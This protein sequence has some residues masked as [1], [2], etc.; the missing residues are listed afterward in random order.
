MT[1]VMRNIA[2]CAQPSIG[3]LC[4]PKATSSGVMSGTALSARAPGSSL[5]IVFPSLTVSVTLISAMAL[6]ST[7]VGSFERIAKSA[8]LPGSRLPLVVSSK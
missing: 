6:G 7:A 2:S 3:P 1:A 8:S 4:P 5:N